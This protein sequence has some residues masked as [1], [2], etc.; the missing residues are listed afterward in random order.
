MGKQ[1]RRVLILFSDTG[2]GHRSPAT[3]TAQALHTLYGNRAQVIM[4]NALADYAPWPFNR[5]EEAYPHM[6]G[7]QGWPWGVGYHLTDGSLIRLITRSLYPL[8]R[9]SAAR[10]LRDY[11]PD[12][13]VS[14]HSVP[15]H[16]LA[17]YLLRNRISIP[18][19][20]IVADLA[21]AHAL[22]LTPH[23]TR[24]LVATEEARQQALA[25]GQPVERLVVTGLPVGQRFIA[26]TQEDPRSVRQRLGLD[27]DRPTAM[28]VNG[29]EGMGPSYRLCKT[30]ASSGLDAQLILIAGR[31]EKLR[32]RL[33]AEKW[34]LPV[35]VE[36]FVHNMHAWMRAS[37]LLVTKAGPSTICEAFILGLPMVLSNAIPGQE[38][39]NAAYVVRAGAGVW[40]PKPAQAAQAVRDLLSPQNPQRAY[41][42]ANAQRL[43]QP[44]AARRVAEV[45]WAAAGNEL[46]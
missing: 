34:P 16:S 7:L 38:R 23:A 20:T 31:N 25:R 15:N 33:T 5:L 8:V 18:L 37:D 13:I 21:A 27:P 11:N 28:I 45:V 4:V 1:I 3:A 40:A 10:L 39:P 6:V 32:A 22:W 46:A 29:A 26:A 42:A 24:C 9:K 17:E 19:I 36:G 35:R 44:E 2:G 43:A 12:V 41:M 30:I 14:F